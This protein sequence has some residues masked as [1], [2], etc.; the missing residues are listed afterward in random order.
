MGFEDE[1]EDDESDAPHNNRA[2]NEMENII[3]TLQ[4]TKSAKV[5]F[6]TN[7]INF[8]SG[9]LKLHSLRWNVIWNFFASIAGI[10]NVEFL[11]FL[12]SGQMSSVVISSPPLLNCLLSFIL[13]F[14]LAFLMFITGRGWNIVIF[15]EAS[16]KTSSGKICWICS[17]SGK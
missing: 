11:V 2:A 8:G 17:L 16:S 4:P 7:E 1:G 6:W 3:S 13:R 10:V 14:F 12:E 5:L 9:F 15:T